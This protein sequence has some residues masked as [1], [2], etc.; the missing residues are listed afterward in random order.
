MNSNICAGAPS[1]R[2]WEKTAAQTGP[3]KIPTPNGAASLVQLRT[4]R[5]EVL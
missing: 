2:T 5:T 1:I 3:G 4:D